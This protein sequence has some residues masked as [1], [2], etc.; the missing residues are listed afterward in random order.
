MNIWLERLRK[1]WQRVFFW[2]QPSGDSHEVKP[3]SHA[4][5]AL[6]LSVT[7]PSTVPSFRQLRF[8]N[9]VLNAGE[10]KIFWGAFFVLL[11]ALMLGTADL[12]ATR[13][14]P[15]PGVGGTYTEGLVGSP[16]LI[17]PL[18]APLNDVDRD[19]TGLIF[20][21]LFRPNEHL[22][23]V[24]DL[25][26]R[27]QWSE[28]GK[29][30]EVTL[31]KDIRFHDGVPLTADDVKFTY[32]AVKNPAARSPLAGQFSG[33]SV[34]RA[35]EFTVQFQLPAPDPSFLISLTLGILPAHIWEDIPD[36]NAHL[37][38]ANLKPVGSG[39]YQVST[40]TRDSRG[41]ILHFNLKRFSSFYGIK[42]LIEEVRMRF[43]PDR[44]QAETALRNGQIDGLAFLPW[45][46]ASTLPGENYA[47]RRIELPQETI[48][49]FN[50]K[51][52]LLKDVHMR[53]ALAMAVDPAELASLLGEHISIATSPYPFLDYATGTKPDLEAARKK[54]ETIGW[55]LPE[56]GTVRQF[57]GAGTSRTATATSTASSTNLVLTILAPNQP[58]LQKVAELL[59]RRW[60]LLGA[61]VTIVTDEPEVLL[62]SALEKRDYQI[63]VTNVLLPPNQDLTAFWAS[64]N[65]SG[66]GLNLSNLADRDVDLAL[67]RVASATNTKQLIEA[68]MLFSDEIAERTPALFLLRPVYA[69]ILSRRIQGTGDLRLLKPADRFLNISSWYVRTS[70]GWR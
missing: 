28:D 12:A 26:E 54:L 35:D 9:R 27:Y 40:F 15:V 8:V 13:L 34:I 63:L 37:A 24:P 45:A 44:P 57:I 68:R 10:R 66:N 55:K 18:F 48:A 59:K 50:V 70:W 51:Q 46:E 5:H 58:D 20:S 11:A 23:P 19:L 65:A 30:L 61:E 56:G 3:H 64:K 36:A 22:E 33:V 25:A 69:Y 38:D 67:E 62:R 47:I 60:S 4:D 39:P 42:P 16:K 6:V 41:Q 43:F 7:K 2:Q 53:E 32:D 29:T 31:R 49:F 1:L 17:N 14:V 21:G 52:D